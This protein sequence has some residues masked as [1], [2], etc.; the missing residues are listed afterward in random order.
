MVQS[1]LFTWPTLSIAVIY[2]CST[3]LLE[4]QNKKW[5]TVVLLTNMDQEK[6]AILSAYVGCGVMMGMLKCKKTKEA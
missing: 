4:S 5:S 3:Y 6:Q 2:S 1:H